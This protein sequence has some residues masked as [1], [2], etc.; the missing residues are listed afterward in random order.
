VTV[1]A[2]LLL[3][4]L[5]R[6]PVVTAPPDEPDRLLTTEETAKRLGVTIAWMHRHGHE[7][8]FRVSLSRKA[9]RYRESGLRKYVAVKRP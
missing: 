1:T 3:A 2:A 6:E 9:P 7:L 4:S 5:A 8:P